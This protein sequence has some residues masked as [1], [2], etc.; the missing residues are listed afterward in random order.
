MAALLNG[1]L[2]D[3]Q[4]KTAQSQAYE[5]HYFVSSPG[6]GINLKAAAMSVV[7]PVYACSIT[8]DDAKSF[9]AC[10]CPAQ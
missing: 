8:H 4:S 3:P 2:A 9:T 10:A 5:S 1:F 7:W 6:T